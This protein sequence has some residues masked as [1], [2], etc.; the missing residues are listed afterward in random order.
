MVFTPVLS[1]LGE[2]GPRL[3]TVLAPGAALPGGRLAGQVRL[4]GGDADCDIDRIT[5]EV[6]ARL[7]TAAEAR[8]LER[9]VVCARFTLPGSF[10]L[11]RGEERSLLFDVR[12][13]W[14]TPVTEWAGQSLG[15]VLGA[16][17]EIAV[18]A[19][20]GRGGLVPLAVA[21]LPVHEA[22]LAALDRLGFG[23]TAATLEYGL[24]P[25]TSQ[26]LPLYQVFTLLPAPAYAG[27]LRELSVTF[28]TNPGGADV[29]VEA[30][31]PGGLFSSGH[32]QLNRH[33]VSHRDAAQR[34]WG[35][36]AGVWV[37]EVLAR[38]GH[39]SLPGP[40]GPGRDR[41]TAGA[42]EQRAQRVVRAESQDG[43]GS[44]AAARLPEPVA[45]AAAARGDAVA[46]PAPPAVR[47]APAD[48]PSVA[49]PREGAPQ[50]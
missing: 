22:L 39:R 47:M 35:A 40:A 16:R 31:R 29:I 44:S 9:E 15:V 6:V 32:G 18:A 46:V 5:V 3:E 37:R 30:D 8:R 34:D 21:P 49:A 17:T 33:I 24:V 13:P 36:T 1:P 2:G 48:R 38:L 19:A 26:R 23:C 27:V 50:V 43:S 28:L 41:S 11:G 12:L 14:E 45:D 4:R 10:R 25:D 42:G 7:G 20:K